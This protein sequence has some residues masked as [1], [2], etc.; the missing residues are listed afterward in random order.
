MRDY[1]M[2]KSIGLAVV[3]AGLVGSAGAEPARCDKG[4]KKDQDQEKACMTAPEIDPSSAIA[5]LT[6]LAGG[7]AVMVGRRAKRG[8]ISG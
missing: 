7:I 5:G 3:L 8:A 4:S 6:L 2:V 1:E